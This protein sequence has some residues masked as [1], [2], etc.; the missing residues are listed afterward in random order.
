[1]RD[2]PSTQDDLCITLYEAYLNI[3]ETDFDFAVYLPD[4]LKK[5]DYEDENGYESLYEAAHYYPEPYAPVPQWCELADRY[6]YFSFFGDERGVYI[7]FKTEDDA[8]A[9]WKYWSEKYYLDIDCDDFYEFL[10]YL[11]SRA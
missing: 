10:Y 2:V 7:F 9:A 4:E 8:K 1:M 3:K 5:T 6:K 11:E